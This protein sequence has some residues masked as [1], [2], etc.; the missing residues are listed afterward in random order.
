[1]RKLHHLQLCLLVA[2]LLVAARASADVNGFASIDYDASSNQVV[3]YCETDMDLESAQYYYPIVNCFIEDGSGY[4]VA[5][6]YAEN[7]YGPEADVTIQAD[8]AA[9]ELYTAEADNSSELYYWRP[10][11]GYYDLYDYSYWLNQNVYAPCCFD[12][13]PGPNG[14]QVAP[15]SQIDEGVTYDQVRTPC[16]YPVNFRQVAVTD[17][18]VCGLV[19]EYRW[20]SS[21]G[22]GRLN[23]LSKCAVGQYVSYPGPQPGTFN[24]PNPPYS[25]SNPNPLVT[26]VAGTDGYLAD[27]NSSGPFVTPYRNAQFEATQYY[28]YRCACASGGQPIALMGPLAIDRGVTQNSNGS[29]KCSIS[30]AG[31]TAILD[32][33]P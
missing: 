4:T 31:S 19:F 29:Y 24:W 2:Y 28:Q 22:A 11:Y 25:G 15:D 21:T 13:Y 18:H 14:S 30:K 16:A 8:A 3:A 17:D 12:Y 33:L 23:D 5:N 20:D 9:D 10:N 7:Q 32:P 6:G 26:S 1:M 27:H